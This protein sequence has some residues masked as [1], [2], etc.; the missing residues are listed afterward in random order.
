VPYKPCKHA[1]DSKPVLLFLSFYDSIVVIEK[2]QR[3]APYAEKTGKISFVKS[4]SRPPSL[5][6]TLAKKSLNT[7]L[8][9]INLTL[10]FLGLRG[11][12]WR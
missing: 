6:N 9:A 11:F 2:R 10:R 8:K 12:I 4:K 5:F 3:E 7:S 1:C